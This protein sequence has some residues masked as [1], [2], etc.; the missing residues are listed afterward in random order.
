MCISEERKQSYIADVYTALRHKGVM[1]E[2]IPMVVGK[3]GFIAAL[4]E[5]PE[6]QLHYAP[7]DAAIEILVTA[8]C[9]K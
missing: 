8:A 1:E 6:D 4:N 7:E 5:Y 3:T 9:A 2:D